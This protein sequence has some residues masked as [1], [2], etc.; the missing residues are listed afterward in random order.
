MSGAHTAFAAAGGYALGSVSFALLLARARGVD[1]RGV[2]SGNL[3][4]TNV[5]R[6]LGRRLGVLTYLLDALKG[7]A[8]ALAAV[9]LTADP[10]AGA[11]A[12]GGAFLGHLFPVWHG[13][14]GGKGVATLSGA[15]LAVAPL[16][17]LAAGLSFAL[18]VRA[19]RMVSAGSIAFGVTLGPAAWVLRAPQPVVLLAALGGC[20]LM[21]THRANIA[22]IRAG[23]EPRIGERRAAPPEDAR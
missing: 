22:R 19:T 11:A 17:A 5:S 15:L 12:G 4:A 23:R 7:F 3:G 14:R 21:F 2:G 9:G 10:A 13:F 8:P 6:A 1:L 16:A 20:A 18:T